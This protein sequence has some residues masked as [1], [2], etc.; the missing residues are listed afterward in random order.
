MRRRQV[1]Q[2]TVVN[3]E[4]IEIVLFTVS[5]QARNLLGLRRLGPPHARAGGEDLERVR[6]EFGGLDSRAFERASSGTMD[7]DSQESG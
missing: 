5:A 3:G 2:V 7:A 1:D 4:R 6:A